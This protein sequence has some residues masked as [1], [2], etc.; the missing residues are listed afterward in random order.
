[1]SA[2]EGEL[3]PSVRQQLVRFQQLQQT[4]NAI[5]VEKQRLELELV[6]VKNALE[7]LQKVS[8]DAAIYKAVGPVLVQTSKQQIV[9]ELT[10][11]K[12]LTETRLKL[13]EKQEQRTREQLE[14]LQKELRMALSGQGPA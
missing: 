2:G 8:D 12:E 4:L 10:E 7:E 3:P 13:L 1:M 6:E 9:E 11:R 5:L 14:S